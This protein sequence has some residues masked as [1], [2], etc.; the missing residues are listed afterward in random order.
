MLPFSPS[1]FLHLRAVA[2]DDALPISAACS[3][4]KHVRYT[5][6]LVDVQRR[7]NLGEAA[8]R[9]QVPLSSI[10]LRPHTRQSGS[11]GKINLKLIDCLE[12][13]EEA[14][15]LIFSLDSAV[16]I[17]SLVTYFVL[18]TNVEQS[19]THI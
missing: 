5:A 11:A 12:P 17:V 7:V 4:G 18:T 8:S 13:P 6:D 9:C 15:L 10:H 1:S 16:E 3:I 2:D 19:L 14:L